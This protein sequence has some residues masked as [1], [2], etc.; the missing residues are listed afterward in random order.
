MFRTFLSILIVSLSLIFQACSVFEY[1]DGSSMEEIENFRSTKQKT[2][3]DLERSKIENINLKKQVEIS[4]KENQ[5]I[6]DTK[7]HEIA[8]TR[9]QNRRLNKGLS[10]QK[11]EKRVLTTKIDGLQ[12]KY[13]TL[14]RESRELGRD[15]GKLKIKVLSGDGDLNSAREMKKKLIDLGYKIKFIQPAPRSNFKQNTLYFASAFQTEAKQLA[16]KLGDKTILKPLTW[17]S[18]YDLIVVTGKNR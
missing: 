6:R 3:S 7:M 9:D 17:N 5:K 16:S 10:R 8:R 14:S 2:Q 18:V 1:L 12:K 11:E 15:I 4:K 13:E